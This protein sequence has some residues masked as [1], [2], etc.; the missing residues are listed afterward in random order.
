MFGLQHFEPEHDEVL[1]RTCP[2]KILGLANGSSMSGLLNGML[3]YMTSA[4]SYRTELS[5]FWLEL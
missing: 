1:G 2:T 5:W 3:S 4:W